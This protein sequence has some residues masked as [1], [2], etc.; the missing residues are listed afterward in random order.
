MSMDKQ[1]NLIYFYVILQ[2]SPMMS[3]FPL[4]GRTLI[5]LLLINQYSVVSHECYFYII[6]GVN[7][8]SRWTKKAA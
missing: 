2:Y 5:W 4:G 7:K 6:V 3:T 8:S 1:Y